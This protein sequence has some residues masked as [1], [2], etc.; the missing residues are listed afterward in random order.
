MTDQERLLYAKSI[1]I[2]ALIKGPCTE[3]KDE[4]DIMR[5]VTRDYLP[6]ARMIFRN[7]QATL[8]IEIRH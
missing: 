1:E 2:A 4:H 8:S 6:L 5:I 7:I 3:A